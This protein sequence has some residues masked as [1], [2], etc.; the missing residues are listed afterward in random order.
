MTIEE[1]YEYADATARVL[2]FCEWKSIEPPAW[3]DKIGDAFIDDMGEF[4]DKYG[5]SLDWIICNRG[6]HPTSY[7]GQ[8][9]S[10]LRLMPE[11]KSQV[12]Y[13]AAEKAEGDPRAFMGYLYEAFPEM[14]KE[15][16]TS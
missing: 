4:C 11:E 14:R 1:D 16:L 2:E 3:A 12:F 6:P 7:E 15:A 10:C 9:L 8:F 5:L 13:D